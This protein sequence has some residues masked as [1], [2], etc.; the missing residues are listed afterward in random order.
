MESSL[1]IW[2]GDQCGACNRLQPAVEPRVLPQ[3]PP[4]REN[5]Y[6]IDTGPGNAKE[7]P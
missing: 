5:G 3:L 2:R 6:A 1:M 7:Q 4:D